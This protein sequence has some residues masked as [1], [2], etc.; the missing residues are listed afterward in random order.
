MEEIMKYDVNPDG[1]LFI[2]LRKEPN[3]A[4]SDILRRDNT[5]TFSLSPN[6]LKVW[7]EYILEKRI[8][9]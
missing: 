2:Y 7:R 9:S 4:L 6:C 5:E 8:Y 3:L 1:F